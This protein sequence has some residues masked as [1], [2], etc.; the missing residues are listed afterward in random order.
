MLSSESQAQGT[1]KV[2]VVD[3]C[4]LSAANTGFSPG[5]FRER[6]V[7]WGRFSVQGLTTLQDAACS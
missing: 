3:E 1:I 7:L 5:D 6:S 2:A 4:V